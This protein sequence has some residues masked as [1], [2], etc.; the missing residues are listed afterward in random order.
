MN[1]TS[2]YDE[3]DMNLDKVKILNRQVR[4]ILEGLD[5]LHSAKD[6]QRFHWQYG[7]V[8]EDLDYLTS[9]LDDYVSAIRKN[10][11]DWL[12]AERKQSQK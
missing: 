12:E 11:N 1:Y 10:N 9:M 2:Q 7:V 6:L 4:Y 5:E 8:K 3:I